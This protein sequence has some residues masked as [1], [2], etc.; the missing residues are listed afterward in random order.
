MCNF[1]LTDYHSPDKCFCLSDYIIQPAIAFNVRDAKDLSPQEHDVIQF[2]NVVLNVGGAY[3]ET[4]G[5][6]TSPV[7]GTFMFSIQT[8]TWISHWGRFQLVVDASSNVIL[9]IAHNS[10]AAHTA[11]TSGTVAHVLTEGQKVWLQFQ[12]NSGTTQVL[13]ESADYASNQFS[14]VLVHKNVNLREYSRN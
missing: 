3:D 7:N 10:T 13:H 8:A 2:K 14:G 4:T 6:F 11:S 12:Y 9:S 5:I 1:S